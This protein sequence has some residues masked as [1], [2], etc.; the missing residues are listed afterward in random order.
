MSLLFSVDAPRDE[1]TVSFDQFF[2]S[3]HLE[4]DRFEPDMLNFDL[5]NQ[6]AFGDRWI[7]RGSMPMPP[8][9]RYVYWNVVR[10]VYPISPIIVE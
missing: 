5:F 6:A 3:M 9:N 8:C 1:G 4:K 10:K 2:E 7:Y